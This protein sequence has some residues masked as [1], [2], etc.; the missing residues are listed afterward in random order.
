MTGDM[1]KRAILN[2]MCGDAFLPLNSNGIKSKEESKGKKWN[3]TSV[4]CSKTELIFTFILY[5]CLCLFL[6]NSNGDQS[7]NDL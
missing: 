5:P 7:R 1:F 6:N 2:Y 3:R 4:K